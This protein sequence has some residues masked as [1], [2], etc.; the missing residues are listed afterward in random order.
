VEQVLI[1]L[2]L[3]GRDALN[4]VTDRP[5][6]MRISGRHVA[7]EIQLEVSDNGAGI[8]DAVLPRLFEPFF[9][10][11]PDGQGTG[12]G[13]SICYGIAR[14]CGGT[15]SAISGGSDHQFGGAHFIL[16]L[17]RFAPDG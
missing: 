6:R 1:N 9:T 15:L 14:S 2:L 11:K 10:T 3:N 16:S 5:R 13:L 4:A 8:P 7:D 17:K 12:L